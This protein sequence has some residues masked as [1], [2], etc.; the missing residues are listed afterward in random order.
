MHGS[1]FGF[2]AFGAANNG[3]TGQGIINPAFGAQM[4]QRVQAQINPSVEVCSRRG[5]PIAEVVMQNPHAPGVNLLGTPTIMK[6]S[7]QVNIPK[8]GV[9][10]RI[11]RYF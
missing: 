7:G 2:T 6:P 10:A 3:N 11:R 9:W 1:N 4:G 5:T 8:A